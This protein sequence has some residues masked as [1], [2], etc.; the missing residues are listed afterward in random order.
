MSKILITGGAGFI[1]SHLVDKLIVQNHRVIII[2][3]LSTG[4]KKFINPRAKF[5]RLDIISPKIKTVFQKEMPDFVFHL[6]AQKSVPFSLKFPLLD[7]QTNI[8]GSLNIIEKSLLVKVKKFIF[9]STGGAIYGHAPQIPSSES[10]FTLPDS[11]YGL[12]KLAVENYLINYYGKIKK[13]NFITLRL[14]NVYG[15]RQDSLGEAGV[16]AVFI[17]R[18]LK[19][20]PCYINGSG[21]QT[22]DFIFVDDVVLACLKS[23]NKGQGIYNIGTGKETSIN[24]LYQIIIDL[25]NIK[26]TAKH[27]PAIAGEVARSVLNCR[28]AKREHKWSP[29]FNLEQGVNRTIDYFLSLL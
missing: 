21:K 22:R 20:Q 2:D 13:L 17:D 3:N 29:Q 14:A 9:I 5:Y 1:G 27:R 23:I 16:I 7:A 6:A 11:P 26:A 24:K 25:L 10:V 19:N 18:L 15:P 8:L 4:R 12:S 28:K